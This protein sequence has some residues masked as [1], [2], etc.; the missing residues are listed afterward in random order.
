[1]ME[2]PRAVNGT[3]GAGGRGIGASTADLWSDRGRGQAKTPLVL[4]ICVNRWF[5]CG[6]SLFCTGGVS[7]S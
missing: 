4:L 6:I 5:S 1:M 2:E 7:K 3:L